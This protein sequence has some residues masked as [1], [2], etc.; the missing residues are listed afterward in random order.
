MFDNFDPV[1]LAIWFVAF[2]LSCTCHEAAHAL[3]ARLGGDDTAYEA[4]QVTLN[5]IPHLRREPFGMIFVP[6]LSFLYAGWMIGWASAPYDPRWAER[7]P[8]RAGLMALAGPTANF[9]LL[10]A[11]LAGIRIM[12]LWGEDV[13]AN[14]AMVEVHYFLKVLA[15]LNALL[16]TFNLMPLPPLDGA[17]VAHA[18]GGSGVR[19]LMGVLE[20][21]PMAGLLGLLIA[22][23]LFGLIA[24]WVFDGVLTMMEPAAPRVSFN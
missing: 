21:M 4:G 11:A 19:R 7:H 10:A 20:S 9:V 8:R 23:Q 3:A 17:A 22:W 16:G 13:F 5:P 18:F 12:L 24:P 2:L 15:V 6:L 14:P 1:A